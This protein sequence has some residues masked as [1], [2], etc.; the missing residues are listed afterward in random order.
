MRR[1]QRSSLTTQDSVIPAELLPNAPK[2]APLVVAPVEDAL[3]LELEL[4]GQ[5]GGQENVGR[6]IYLDA[7]ATTPVDPR[8]VDAMLPYLTNQYGN[9][10]SRTHAYGWESEKAVEEARQVRPAIAEHR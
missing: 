8:V 2:K 6:P 9:P 3:G 10:H 7:Q 1:P 4:T 5:S